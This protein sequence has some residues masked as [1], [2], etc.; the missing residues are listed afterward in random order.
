[1]NPNRFSSNFHCNAQFTAYKYWIHGKA[2]LRVIKPRKLVA[3]LAT[4][5]LL[6]PGLQSAGAQTLPGGLS[7]VQGSARVTTAGNMLTVT[8]SPG[9]LL[10]WNSFSIGAQSIVR[11]D[12]LNASSQVLNRVVGNDPSSILGRSEERRVGKECV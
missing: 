5:L 6:M 3:A 1:M 2:L 4:S 10:N 9:A 11:F 12:Q 8:N 7:V